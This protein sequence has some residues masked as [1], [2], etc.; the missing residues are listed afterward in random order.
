MVD[1]NHNPIN[2]ILLR[3]VL[4]E[5]SPIVARVISIPD[6]FEISDLHDVFLTILDWDYDPEFII[7]IHAQEFASFR[8]STRAHSSMVTFL[9]ICFIHC[10]FGC[11]VMPATSTRRLSR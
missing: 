4:K 8:R 11:G 5:V 6:S 10:S 2:R 9:T 1:K 7:R 3:C